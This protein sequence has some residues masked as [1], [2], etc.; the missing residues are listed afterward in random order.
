MSQ[1]TVVPRKKFLKRDYPRAIDQYIDYFGGSPSA[2]VS[3]ESDPCGEG[4]LD[5]LADRGEPTGSE[6]S[7][8]K[9]CPEQGAILKHIRGVPIV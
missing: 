4:L 9:A 1:A 8:R 7:P 2:G 6:S 3:P 5:T